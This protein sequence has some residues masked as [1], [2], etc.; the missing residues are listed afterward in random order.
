MIFVSLAEKVAQYTNLEKDLFSFIIYFA[1]RW[2]CKC[3]VRTP[4]WK[5]IQKG[6]FEHRSLPHLKTY[7]KK[8]QNFTRVLWVLS[9]F[10]YSSPLLI[11]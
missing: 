10:P 3:A 7:S 8:N 2:P 5:H 1:D 9:E 6:K 11:S 4:A